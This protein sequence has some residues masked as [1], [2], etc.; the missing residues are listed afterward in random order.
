MRPRRS[1][2]LPGWLLAVAVPLAVVGLIAAYVRAEL[3]DPNRFA[4]HAVTALRSEQ[5]R[6]VIAEQVA[7]GLLERASPDLVASRPLVLAAVEAVLDTDAFAQVLRS[8]AVAVH[9][10]LLEGD[11]DV[12][13]ELQ[14]AAEVLRPSLRTV[15]PDVARAIPTDVSPRIAAIRRSDAGVWAARVAQGSGIAAPLLLVAAGALLLA[16]IAVAEDRQRAVRQAGVALVAIGV[17][18]LAIVAALRAQT[19]AH[20]SEVGVVAPEDARAAAGAAWDALAG[21]LARWF[22]IAALGGTVLVAATLL[23]RARVDRAGALRQAAE[24]VAGGGLPPAARAARGALLV[25]AGL[26][27]ALGGQEVRA[28]AAVTV[29]LCLAVLGLTELVGLASRSA[30]RLPRRRASPRRRRLVL[31]AGAAVVVVAVALTLAA[32]RTGDA[33]P[34]AEDEIVACNG[35][36]SLCSKRLDQV[37]FAG[38]HNSMSAA[39]RP[40]WFF[41]NQK[42]AIPRQLADGIRLLLVD[43]HYGIADPRGRIRTDL[44][45]EGTTRNRVAA[46]L[47]PDATR[48]AEQL[49]GRLGLVLSNGKRAIY[50]CHSLC[51]LGAEPLRDTLRDLRGFLER[52]RAEVVVVFLESSV[53]PGEIEAAFEKAKLEPYLATLPRG[54][55]PLPTL[56][57]MIASGRRLVVLDQG[58]G[59]DA[60]WYQPGFLFLQDTQISSLLKSRTA[61]VAGRGTPDSPLLFMNQWIDR[62]PPPAAENRAVGDRRSLLRRAQ[63]CRTA[64]GRPVNAIAVDFYD[65]SDV[66]RTVR[67]LNEGVPRG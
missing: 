49:A 61:C 48:A 60:P 1:N 43:P 62:F 21:G 51:E 15:A 7:V 37:V 13:V 55:A 4:D 58:D 56:R 57:E 9:G 3:A 29:A 6:D 25:A 67:E 24:L 34:P 35:L 41:A 54:G 63:A 5:A 12:V 46:K 39:D 17:A 23:V 53:E 32:T 19:V 10:L 14:D 33:D 52:N 50:L 47:G 38:T 11:R 8:T 65:D 30:G 2:R 26:L 40:G 44:E 20:A 59:G 27:V 16:A 42:R 22:Q 28:A 36:P 18:G 66:L 64:L 31:S 45:A